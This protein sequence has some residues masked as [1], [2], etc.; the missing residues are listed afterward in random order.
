MG[1]DSFDQARKC[2]TK[3][4][5][6]VVDLS[7]SDT[8]QHQKPGRWWDEGDR[9]SD[10]DYQ[11]NGGKNGK[12][13]QRKNSGKK[14]P[15]SKSAAQEI[16][17]PEGPPANTSSEKDDVAKEKRRRLPGN[18]AQ[19]REMVPKLRDTIDDEKRK[20]KQLHGR[21]D[22]LKAEN[23]NLNKEI[24]RLK[25]QLQ[26][27]IEANIE[28]ENDYKELH[29]DRLNILGKNNIATQPDDEVA[30][31]LNRIFR[32]TRSFANQWALDNWCE[33]DSVQQG[34]PVKV[35]QDD[36]EKKFVSPR[37]VS[38]AQNMK[39]APKYI[40]NAFIN[41][42]ICIDTF[43][44]PF[45]YLKV[46]GVEPYDTGVELV[47]KWIMSNAGLEMGQ[48]AQSYCVYIF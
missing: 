24:D 9:D 28:L 21:T 44:R 2:P 25:S 6:P 42:H 45:G 34:N 46:D 12:E 37:C 35:L 23:D 22:R 27:S 10:P 1:S 11:E 3:N 15:K 17:R 20:L 33:A 5:T 7:K 43:N 14:D 47:L 29:D 32:D 40:V 38:A 30:K 26:E 39:I 36:R 4:K 18:L 31:E 41:R 48:S 16:N 13:G 19:A 8:E